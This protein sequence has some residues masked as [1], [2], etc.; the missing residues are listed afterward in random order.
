VELPKVDIPRLF[1]L[2]GKLASEEHYSRRGVGL[3]DAS[4]VV[5]ARSVKGSVWSLDKKLN[6]VLLDSERYSITSER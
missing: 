5:A 4:I 3:I 1:L 6:A 2:A